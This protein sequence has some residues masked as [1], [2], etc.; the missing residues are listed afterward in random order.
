M[1][2]F[3]IMLNSGLSFERALSYAKK[4]QVVI[5]NNQKSYPISVAILA[6]NYNLYDERISMKIFDKLEKLDVKNLYS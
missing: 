2:N 1:N 4:G 5:T 6:H 3:K